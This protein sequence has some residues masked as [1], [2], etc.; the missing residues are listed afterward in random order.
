MTIVKARTLIP[1]YGNF[2]QSTL[3]R[4]GRGQMIMHFYTRQ[5][6]GLAV[7]SLM[8]FCSCG[9]P[10]FDSAAMKEHA[11]RLKESGLFRYPLDEYFPETPVTM[12]EPPKGENY[13]TGE[14][15]YAPPGTAVYAIGNGVI[16]Y[17]GSARGYGWLI[18]IDHPWA[19]IYSL[20]GHLSPS[21][22]RETGRLSG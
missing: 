4:S 16:R 14:D 20:Y 11:D 12:T 17:S 18:I 22:Q 8:V 2:R 7:A 9:K 3:M 19:N 21:R 6:F 15:S 1:Q 10:N 13:H 5:S